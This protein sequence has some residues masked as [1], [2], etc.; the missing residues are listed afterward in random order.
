MPIFLIKW[1]ARYHSSLS[2]MDKKASTVPTDLDSTLELDFKNLSQI[3]LL[4]KQPSKDDGSLVAWTKYGPN[5][6]Y[7]YQI[8][9]SKTKTYKV[10]A[11][12]I[13]FRGD[14]ESDRGLRFDSKVQGPKLSL[15]G[16]YGVA[17]MWDEDAEHPLSILEADPER[18][19]TAYF[20]L[21]TESE[22]EKRIWVPQGRITQRY[23]VERARELTLLAARE[24]ERKFTQERSELP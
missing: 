24:Q 20:Y 14:T 8:G 16:I 7:I 18:W 2:K 9:S 21:T 15:Y 19:R 17:W 10:R 6:H 13:K 22:P 11:E 23:W 5:Y 4:E 3:Q 1:I 12:K